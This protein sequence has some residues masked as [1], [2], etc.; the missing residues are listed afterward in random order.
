V[1]PVDPRATER[2]QNREP[3][4]EAELDDRLDALLN[5]VLSSR[6][7]AAPLAHT[8]A[9]LER[10]AQDFALHWVEVIGRTN[11]EMAYQFAAAA[12][13]ALAQLDSSAAE[14]WIIQAMD[15]YDRE[16]LYHGSQVFKNFSSFVAQA[17]GEHA[18]VYE[19]VAH[20]L[21]LF[22][23][24]L[25]GRR[26]K[27]DT[28][29]VAWTDTNTIYLPPRMTAGTTRAQNFLI[30]K[31][32]ATLLWA[33]SRYGTF[34]ADLDAAVQGLADPARAL[35]WLNYFETLR[36]E[37]QIARTLPG[38]ARD[39]LA[40]GG[41]AADNDAR[42]LPLRALDASVQDSITLLHALEPNGDVP[43]HAWMGMLRPA[44][45]SATRSARLAREKSELRAALAA[46]LEEQ[47]KDSANEAAANSKNENEG[48]R[49]EVQLKPGD[50]DIEFEL[51][52]D[53]EP[54]APPDN[55]RNLLDSVLQDLGDIPDDYLTLAS[56]GGEKENPHADSADDW[57]SAHQ[58]EGAH[59]YN[60]WDHKRRHYR[61]NWCVLRELD[62]H[63]GDG[64]FVD[65]TLKKYRPQVTQLRRS[66]EMLRG[67]DRLIKR[68]K[69]GDDID[70]DA[71]I[72]GYAD[73]R[74]G[75][76]LS[77]RLFTKRHKAERNL[78]VMF[79]V[80]M[81]G[82]TKGW[83]NDAE[84]EALVLLSEALEVL[85]DR[86]AI[87]G[88][89]GITRKR[90]EI[91]RVKRFDEPY[92]DMVQRRIAGVVPQDYT[93]MGVAIRHLTALLEEVDA[94][95]KLLITLSDGKPDDYSDNYRGEYGIEDT[96]QALLEAHRAGIKP[97][98][99]TIDHEA[100]DYLPH[101]YGAVNWTLVDD[102][103]RLPIKVADIYRKLTT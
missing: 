11:Y 71:V 56:D 60:E 12:P 33:Q 10:T 45:A 34:N 92:S 5:P 42:Y 2:E 82:S 25:S 96:R 6:R 74:S 32:I 51:H 35:T 70:L 76:E 28:A 91:F 7:T 89:S 63:P 102:V 75:R 20:V 4:T 52:L 44:D 38:L 66:F 30:Y 58:D 67:E 77:D 57:K 62:V 8:L 59:F 64:A 13:D 100:R 72:A 95:T 101:M 22:V 93:R 79:M 80:D 99:I 16:G 85:G 73:M 39:L 103:S 19:S 29:P 83:I 43:H 14:A 3:L 94:R 46:L 27:I 87:Y 84:R 37:A 98:C 49:F 53:G 40:L 21:A 18:V 41:N 55:V 86:Y 31:I 97:F 24:G 61:K 17:D 69:H 88:F 36:L 54:I 48:D 65:A 23:C 47:A 15:S 9:S 78:A 68:M 90:C 1:R 50:D 26:M 81:S